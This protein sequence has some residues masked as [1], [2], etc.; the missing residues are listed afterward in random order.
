[1]DFTMNYSE[2]KEFLDEKVDKYNQPD[3][4]ELDPLQ[5][6]HRF[7]KKQDIEIAGF[8]VSTI[9]WGRREMIIKSGNQMLNALDNDP[10]N[11]IINSEDSDLLSIPEIKHRTFNRAD[12]IFF[13]RALKNIY[14]SY[15]DMETVFYQGIQQDD[16]NLTNAISNFRNAF[17]SNGQ[18]HHAQKH[19]SN[20]I[21]GSASKRLCMFLRWMVRNDDR[22]VDLGIWN[23]ISPSVLSCPLDVHTA[24]VG[25]KLNFI[26]RKQND[27]KSVVELD[28]HLRKL[29]PIDPVKYDFALFSLGAIER[30]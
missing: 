19:V 10:Y 9:A 24:N 17:F 20:P 11:F 7:S 13:I 26:S 16:V 29:D 18:E 3:F 28:T 5:F 14:T 6:P 15:A 23:K 4:I 12:F 2:L 21:K 27:W 1:M 22:N 30:W 25:R 8:L